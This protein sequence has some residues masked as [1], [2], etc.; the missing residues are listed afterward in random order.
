VRAGA[1]ISLHGPDGL[2]EIDVGTYPGDETLFSEYKGLRITSRLPFL[3]RLIVAAGPDRAVLSYGRGLDITTVLSSD[4]VMSRFRG[5]AFQRTVTWEDYTAWVEEELLSIRAPAAIDET[6]KY[7]HRIYAPWE[8]Q[9]V[10]RM[11]VDDLERVWVGS[12]WFRV[13]AEWLVLDRNL[14]PIAA[15]RFPPRF[16]LLNVKGMEAVGVVEDALGRE[17]VEVRCIAEGAL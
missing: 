7:Y 1:T 5:E 6:R 2:L 13:E 9:A 8:L 16:R 3:G 11:F 10:D 14:Q 17:S 15:V 4:F 12:E